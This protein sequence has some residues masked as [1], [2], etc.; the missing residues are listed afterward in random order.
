MLP[1]FFQNLQG[2]SVSLGWPHR[3]PQG[4]SFSPQDVDV[5]EKRMLEN[6]KETYVELLD[7]TRSLRSK[8]VANV[9]GVRLCG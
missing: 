7:K 4:L 8:K 5:E 6:F 3:R 1:P 9:S 2:I